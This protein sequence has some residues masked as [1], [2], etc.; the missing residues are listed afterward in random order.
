M[1][2]IGICLVVLVLGMGL[3]AWGVGNML[4]DASFEGMPIEE[5]TGATIPWW[6]YNGG[7]EGSGAGAWVAAEKAKGSTQAAKLFI[8]NEDWAWCVV[9]QSIDRGIHPGLVYKASI[10]VIRQDAIDPA[11]VELK[12]EW[13][14]RG[15]KMLST[16]V[17]PTTLTDSS[18]EGEWHTLSHEFKAPRNA[19]AAK[20]EIVYSKSSGD[21]PPDVYADNARFEL[22][23]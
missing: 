19:H 13:I 9:G 12:I 18:A 22:V 23:E 14:D 20:F 10:D 16:V 5:I 11:L 6:S 1:K 21:D 3:K 17:A 4:E 8:F 7:G 15:G 2:R